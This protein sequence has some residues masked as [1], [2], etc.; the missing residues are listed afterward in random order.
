[1]DTITKVERVFGFL[2]VSVALVRLIVVGIRKF[3]K[4]IFSCVRI[5][6]ARRTTSEEETNDAV[7]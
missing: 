6:N 4:K 3:L 5:K 1:M 2:L 7:F